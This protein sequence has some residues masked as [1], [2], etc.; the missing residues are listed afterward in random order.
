M[1]FKERSFHEQLVTVFAAGVI[2]MIF[3]KILFF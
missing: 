1:N 2:I 3:L